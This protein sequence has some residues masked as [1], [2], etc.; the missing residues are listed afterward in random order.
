MVIETVKNGI[1]AGL[2]R[3]PYLNYIFARNDELEA[4]NAGL[5]EEL[6]RY[7]TWQP[8]GHYYS[9]IPDLAEVHA[10]ANK[11]FDQ[12]VRTVAGIDLRRAEQESLLAEFLP[13]YAEQPFTSQAEPG[14]RYYFDNPFFSYADAVY[15]YCLMR[16]RHPRRIIEVGSGYSSCVILDTN[17]LFF[18]G[19]IYCT[20]IEPY[21]DLLHRLVGPEM[22]ET[23][24]IR[25]SKLQD[26][27]L[28]LFDELQANDIL[29]VDSTH[30]AKAGSDV[31]TLF[32]DVLPRLKPGV[33]VHLHDIFY[34]FEYRREWLEE[35]RAWNE[36]YLLRAFLQYN[37]SFRILF[38]SAYVAVTSREWL[39][40]NM[41]LCLEDVGGS[42][43]FERAR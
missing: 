12:S 21:P 22:N 39:R 31:N 11:L 19:S 3:L 26:V 20:H 4:A 30:V 5:Q 17:D 41:P 42:L 18:D 23:L 16:H 37:H 13:Y 1:K 33:L 25:Q 9:P 43:W 29:F 36:A 40:Q 38:F 10:Q 2:R 34:P 8:P 27:P 35:G 24:D 6:A 14:L 15:L 32:F 7:M 28:A